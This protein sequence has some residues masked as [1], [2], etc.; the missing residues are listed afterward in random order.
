MVTLGFRKLAD[1][2]H[3]REGVGEGGELEGALERPVDLAPAFG[4][5][6]GSI[7]DRCRMATSTEDA[8]GRVEADSRR[9][10]RE[11][12][13]DFVFRP[14]SNAMVPLLARMRVA[15]AAVVLANA[16][17]G[18]VAALAIVR[19][20]LVAGAVLLQLKTLLDNSDGQLARVS[21]RV[22]LT[23]R[24]LDTEADLVVNAAIFAALGYATGEAVLAAAAFV[25]LTIVLA[26]D[27]NVTELH[28]EAR[29]TQPSP[30]LA[31]GTRRE[32]VLERNYELVFRPLDRGVRRLWKGAEVD[33]VAT[34]ILANLG[35]STQLVV[36]GVC[37][38]L[39]VPE[40]YLWIVLASLV[41][42]A[43]LAAR[44]RREV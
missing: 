11:L 34:T 22:T 19:G 26:V 35:L 18:L 25:A 24:Y 43:A 8:A 9:A 28:R 1:A 40:A 42:V 3:E 44:R 36:L 21:G 10:G 15:P 27:F 38:V 33:S 30:P 16:A 37:L 4:A 14:L 12:A 13:L 23:G 6:D 5:H 29:G 7:Y 32:R 20:E 31:T 2:V 41:P 39:G 17:V